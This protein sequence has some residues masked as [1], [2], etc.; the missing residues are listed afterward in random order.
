MTQGSA[1]KIKDLR[2]AR[3]LTQ[4]E[5]AEKLGVSRQTVFAIE[6]GRSEPSLELAARLCSLLECTIEEMF[7]DIFNE[8]NDISQYREEVNSMTQGII[9][10]SPLSDLTDL[11]R[12]ID[13]F[14]EGAILSSKS[15]VPSLGAMNIKDS[16]ENYLVE[17]SVPGLTEDEID[18]EAGDDFLTV[19]GEKKE[20]SKDSAQ[21]YLRREFSHTNFE[22]TVSFSGKIAPDKIS[23]KVS[24]GTLHITL[25]KIAPEKPKVTKVKVGK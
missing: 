7:S 6:S 25:P 12:D 11:H 4:D 19:K 17:I 3:Q 24:H 22:R 13:R 10:F 16:G 5:L 21:N 18:I 8:F 23:A 2:K 1:I 20:E 15:D 14:F 9:P